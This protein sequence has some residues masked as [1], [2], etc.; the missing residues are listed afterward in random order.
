MK[1]NNL[2]K[3]SRIT[4]LLG[5]LHIVLMPSLVFAQTTMPYY[6][7]FLT[8]SQPTGIS[9]PNATVNSA[10]FTNKGLVLTPAENNK[11]G[12]VLL[13]NFSFSNANGIQIE[14]EYAMYGGAGAD[15][16]TMFLYDSE[17]GGNIGAPG[18][19]L[20]Y[21]YN[22]NS[23]NKIKGLKGGYLAVGLDQ[24]GNGKYQVNG[25]SSRE[26]MQ[27]VKGFFKGDG[28]SHVLIRG[29]Y[30][31]Q[32]A[33]DN[34]KY[35]YGYPLLATQSTSTTQGTV[36]NYTGRRLNY[37]SGTYPMENNEPIDNPFSLRG[38]SDFNLES[39]TG[40]RKAYITL[41][42]MA[43]GGFYVTV[44]IKANTG[45]GAVLYTVYQNLPYPTSLKYPE[46]AEYNSSDVEGANSFN[47]QSLD[48]TP[49]ENFKIGFS[50]S[51]GALNQVN[52]IK[53]LTVSLPYMPDTVDD[54]ENHCLENGRV[55][56]LNPFQNDLIY[57]GSMAGTNVPNPSN[58][59]AH[60]DFKSF[61]FQQGS[62]IV[63]TSDAQKIV[64]NDP[65]KG[66]WTYVFS[67]G[68]VYFE[69]KIGFFGEAKIDYTIKGFG[70]SVSEGPFG[71]ELYRSVPK[72]IT[73][74]VLPCGGV[75]NPHL[76]SGAAI[77]NRI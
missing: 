58:D 49:P 15:G 46:N 26:T 52:L 42:P 2:I 43:S 63:G 6:E 67:E 24:F 8:G 56:T 37:S 38:S 25:G 73:I 13:E 45:N 35:F 66:V 32:G 60:I 33:D 19:G 54:Y 31:K 39:D 5:L 21:L 11:N 74:N 22:R 65:T 28:R 47:I 9:V 55:K 17:L 30:N 36:G 72:S 27:G 77:H 64:F 16:I 48:T 10:K 23:Q 61:K 51:T 3:P 4:F 20:G 1:L 75:V 34:S 14:F 44:K 59:S 70:N 76:S 12:A 62:Q 53:N 57:K 7:S 18:K 41:T 71:Q 50:A 29:A 40:Y 68:K 69:P